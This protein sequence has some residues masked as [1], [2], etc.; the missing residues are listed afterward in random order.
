MLYKLVIY[1]EIYKK[2]RLQEIG[3]AASEGGFDELRELFDELASDGECFTY[4]KERIYLVGWALARWY[5]R[6]DFGISDAEK[7]QIDN[8]DNNG[9]K[10]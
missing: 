7:C 4:K 3:K 10:I 9:R 6:L 8:I 2:D 1:D 5:P